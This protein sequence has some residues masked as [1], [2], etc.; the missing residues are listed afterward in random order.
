[1]G[2]TTFGKDS[3][4]ELDIKHNLDDSSIEIPI[5]IYIKEL[6]IDFRCEL[7]DLLDL[8]SDLAKKVDENSDVAEKITD[9]WHKSKDY[10][11]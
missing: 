4:I 10:F 1:M 6:D 2:R 9:L 7:S 3:N 11:Q 8:I 5:N